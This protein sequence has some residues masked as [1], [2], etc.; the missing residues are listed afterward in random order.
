MG[1]QKKKE[2]IIP[3]ALTMQVVCSKGHKL[4]G[5]FVIFK[6]IPPKGDSKTE[7]LAHVLEATPHPGEAPKAPIATGDK[8]KDT[9]ANNAY[10]KRKTAYDDAFKKYEAAVDK[11]TPPDPA[12]QFVLGIVDEK[13]YLQPV[14]AHYNPWYDI[15]TDRDPDAYKLAVGEKYRACFLR[16]PSPAV[17]RALTRY[18]NEETAADDEKYRFDTWG[19]LTREVAVQALAGT[20]GD[21][22]A[23]KLSEDA[24][25]YVPKGSDTYGKWMLYRDMPHA[26]CET[27]APHVEQVQKDIAMLR[28]PVGNPESPFKPKGD[29]FDGQ[30]QAAVARLQEHVNEGKSFVLTHKDKAHGGKEAWSYVLGTP[31]EFSPST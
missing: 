22:V 17:A 28:Y 21:H 31:F 16:H 26:A 12:D 5:L 15:A 14:H 9:A 8:K 10:K 24:E 25:D 3:P 6:L 2:A 30:V 11:E 29:G 7:K 19:E 4:S 27:V 13:G 18:L 20:G 1:K 23:F